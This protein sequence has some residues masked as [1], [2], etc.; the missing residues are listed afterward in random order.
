MDQ[1]IEDLSAEQ[2]TSAGFYEDLSNNPAYQNSITRGEIKFKLLERAKALK[3]KTHV[4][5]Q[6]AVVERGLKEKEALDKA[7]GKTGDGVTR[8]SADYN[9]KSYPDLYCGHWIATDD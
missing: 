2:L 9:G 5:E 4:S 1:K 7:S 8:F 6:L 3:I